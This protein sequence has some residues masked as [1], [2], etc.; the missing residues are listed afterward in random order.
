MRP[1]L[2]LALAALLLAAVVPGTA[3]AAD[4]FDLHIDDYG[5]CGW[6][7]GEV[8]ATLV[9]SGD[10]GARSVTSVTGLRG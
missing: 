7:C 10:S 6:T 5:K 2:R 3:S 9:N 1:T 8:T 4:D